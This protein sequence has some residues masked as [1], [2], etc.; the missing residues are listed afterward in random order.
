MTACLAAYHKD[1]VRPVVFVISLIALNIKTGK[2]ALPII[3]YSLCSIHIHKY[4]DFEKEKNN[5]KHIY[6]EKQQ[7]IFFVGGHCG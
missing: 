5:N 6:P 3:V 2:N 1:I 4:H 7:I